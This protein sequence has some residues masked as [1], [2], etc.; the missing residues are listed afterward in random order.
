MKKLLLLNLTGFFSQMEERMRAEG[1][2][3]IALHANKQ[4]HKYNERLQA[5]KSA[6]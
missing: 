3:N 2:S 6:E 5:L 1:R 4:F